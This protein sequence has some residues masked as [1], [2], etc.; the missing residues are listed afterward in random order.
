VTIEFRCGTCQK[1]LRT[2][3]DK[4]GATAKCPQCGSPV[5]VPPPPVKSEPPPDAFDEVTEPE[6]EAEEWTPP[7]SGSGAGKRDAGP[8]RPCPMC[9]EQVLAAAT[10]CR[11]CG[12]QLTP[13]GGRTRSRG[14]PTTMDAGTVINASWRIYQR[15]MGVVLGLVILGTIINMVV[16]FG[17]GMLSGMVQVAI[18]QNNPQDALLANLVGIP[19]QNFLPLVITS[20]VFGG[21]H[22]GLLKA[23]RGENAEVSDLFAGGRYYLRMLVCSFLFQLMVLIGAV[24]CVVPAIILALMFWPYTYVLV[25]RDPPGIGALSEAKDVTQNN[26]GQVFVLALAAFGINLLGLIAACVGLIFT[27]PLTMLMF[28][29][30]YCHMT[31]QATADE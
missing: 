30:A 21:M 22:L 12:E 1:L 14:V 19:I 27:I 29:V 13:E 8:M 24:L 11:Y 4:A 16:G 26:W 2:S 6:P 31:G 9:G 23:A 7:A 25:D 5:L 20:F 10:R 28:A 17:A 15:N 3:D 18:L